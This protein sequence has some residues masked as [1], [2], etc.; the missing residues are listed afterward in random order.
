MTANNVDVL[1]IFQVQAVV[2][3]RLGREH[4]VALPCRQNT[5]PSDWFNLR[6]DELGEV[7][8]QLRTNITR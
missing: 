3:A 1:H 4:F 7:A 8:A 5:D 2:Q 6:I